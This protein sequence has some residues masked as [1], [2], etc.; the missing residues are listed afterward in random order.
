MANQNVPTHIFSGGISLQGNSFP[1]T[2]AGDITY[3]GLAPTFVYVGADKTVINLNL[4]TTTP[5]GTD[6]LGGKAPNIILADCTAGN[7]TV[8]LPPANEFV[9]QIYQIYF[10]A[11]A[12]AGTITFQKSDAATTVATIT[13]DVARFS[14]GAAAASAASGVVYVF[15]NSASTVAATDYTSVLTFSAAGPT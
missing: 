5:A 13:N 1:S 4:N 11:L 9:G 15:N 6:P 8:V 14:G 10:T 12:A 2:A 3:G 7:L